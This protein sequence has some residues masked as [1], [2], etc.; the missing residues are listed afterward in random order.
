MKNELK[1]LWRLTRRPVPRRVLRWLGFAGIIVAITV[2]TFFVAIR[3]DAEMWGWLKALI[4]PAVFAAVGIF[5]G[6]WFTRQHAQD[7]ALQGYLDKMSEM[8]IDGGLQEIADPYDAMRVTA[9]ART[10][11]VLTQLDG[12]RK[13]TILLFLRES[14]LINSKVLCRKGQVAAQSRLVGLKDADFSNAH[15]RNVQIVS[16]D[17]METVSMEGVVL[18]GADL[19]YATLYGADL[20]GADLR[21]VD[22]RH[23]D[24]S[25]VNLGVLKENKRAADVRATDLRGADLRQA[26]GLTQR[27]IAETIGDRATQLPDYLQ[28]PETW[29]RPART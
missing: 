1:L 19:R 22:L 26:K 13:R 4:L 27:Q 29:R 5:G 18:E 2:V 6:A 24:L 8:L 7:S 14:R 20:R 25:G 12:K 11:A 15:L 10:L 16:T 3:F 21:S 9:R 23:A 28:L 17:R